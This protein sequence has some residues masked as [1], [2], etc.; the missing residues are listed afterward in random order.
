MAN[1]VKGE[2]PLVVGDTTYTLHL[3]TNASCEVEA[4]SGRS[5]EELLTRIQTRRS[6]TD[7]RLVLWASLRKHHRDLAI[8]GEAGLRKVGD[9]LDEWAADDAV[10]AS[11]R[12]LIGLNTDPGEQPAAGKKGARP[13]KAQGGS[14]GRSTGKR[15]RPA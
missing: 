7:I 3:G 14:G 8:D 1:P 6:I 15:S 9:A 2:C 10:V 13:L 11:L 5:L 12:Q 4:L